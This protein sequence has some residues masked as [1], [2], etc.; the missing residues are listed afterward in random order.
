MI[1]PI[2]QPFDEIVVLLLEEAL[3]G[4][5]AVRAADEVVVECPEDGEPVGAQ[6]P[7][8]LKSG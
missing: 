8:S 7:L 6:S 2:E 1:D 5:R 4:G 3:G